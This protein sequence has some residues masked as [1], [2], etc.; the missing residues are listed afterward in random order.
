M[1]TSDLKL[2]SSM[3]KSKISKISNNSKIILPYVKGISTL[4]K[5]V[6]KS[7]FNSGGHHN[8][9][10]DYNSNNFICSPRITSNSNKISNNISKFQSNFVEIKTSKQKH[11]EEPL[12]LK[13]DDNFNN[14]YSLNNN[15]LCNKN[16]IEILNLKYNE[17]ISSIKNHNS[18]AYVNSVSFFT[19]TKISSKS[20]RKNS[21]NVNQWKKNISLN[22]TNTCNN[23]VKD[24]MKNNDK[25]NCIDF[26]YIESE[27][28]LVN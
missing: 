11:V 5:E 1:F 20:V 16:E 13:A 15:H 12:I 6:I 27:E 9:D 14:R 10:D 4:K 19:V 26:N 17:D 22:N 7:K 24:S 28:P 21:S 23:G 3:Q 2:S 25:E 18:I 8:I